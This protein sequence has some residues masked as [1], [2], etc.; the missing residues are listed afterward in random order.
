MVTLHSSG[1]TKLL[2]T[3]R[4]QIPNRRFMKQVGASLQQQLEGMKS[5]VGRIRAYARK[6]PQAGNT[7][8]PWICPATQSEL[9]ARQCNFSRRSNA[10]LQ[11]Q[12]SLS[13]RNSLPY[14]FTNLVGIR[15]NW[16]ASLAQKPRWLV[17]PFSLLKN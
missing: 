13:A 12:R 2:L 15:L 17:H 14:R 10:L 1:N 11:T 3:P 6:G 4:G 8:S 7:S 9:P 5:S 16:T